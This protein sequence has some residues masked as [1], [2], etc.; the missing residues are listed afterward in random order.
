MLL[1]G[2]LCPRERSW[3]RASS[4]CCPSFAMVSYPFD[5]PSGASVVGMIPTPLL[6]PRALSL[7]AAAFGRRPCPRLAARAAGALEL[8]RVRVARF[9]LARRVHLAHFELALLDHR[10]DLRMRRDNR[11]RHRPPLP[12]R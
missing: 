7:G 3:T 2:L 5:L 6:R 10:R 1:D 9:A 8:L 11:A 12:P 4:L